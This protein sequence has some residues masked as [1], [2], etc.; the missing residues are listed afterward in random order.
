MTESSLP[1]DDEA[2]CNVLVS[3]PS[4]YPSSA[5]PQ[6]Q[7][8]SRYIGPFGVDASLFGAILRTYI[9][10]GGVEWVPDNVCVFDGLE[11]VKE[12]CIEWFEAKKSEKLAGELLRED[13][14]GFH[15]HDVQESA[16]KKVSDFHIEDDHPRLAVGLPPGL[17]VVEAEPITDRKSAFVGRAC[18]ITDPSQVCRTIF[19]FI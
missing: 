13:E 5:A 17:N 14:R 1:T 7:L 2:Q 6:L 12:R 18:K 11:W 10:T 9:S 16:D 19:I 3:L 15:A 4:V 8:L